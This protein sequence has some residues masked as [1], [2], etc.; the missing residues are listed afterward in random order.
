MSVLNT[1]QEEITGFKKTTN[2]VYPEMGRV[3]DVIGLVI[4]SRGPSARIGDVCHILDVETQDLIVKAEVVGFRDG[5]IQLMPFGELENL[6]VG[7]WVMNTHKPLTVSLSHALKGRILDALGNPL[8]QFGPVF[9][10]ETRPILATPPDA[11]SRDRITEILPLGVRAL[12][13]FLTMGQGQRMGIF[14]GSG[15]GKS[16]LQGMIARNTQADIN[17][18]ALIGE[19]GREVREFIEDALGEEGLSR[20]IVIV[21]TSEQAPVL[22]IKAA[23]TAA[24]IAEWFRDQ[25]LNVMF[26]LDSV[27]R[28]AMALREVG[29]AIGEPPTSRGYTPSVFTFLPKLLERCGTSDVGSITGL[30]TVLVEGD[31]FN[32]PIA[33]AVRG[34]L[35][36]HIVLSRELAY[37]NH[38]PAIDIL[39]SVSR[40]MHTI[41][42][43]EHRQAAGEIRDLI[44]TYQKSEDIISIGAYVQGANAKLDKAV[45]L[46]DAIDQFLKQDVLEDE[47]FDTAC[48]KL[49]QILS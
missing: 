28:I 41:S 42:E 34:I 18:I 10:E 39:S 44:A 14:A 26:M 43:P 15:V 49:K 31:D 7:S 47:P 30:Y 32:E 21:A 48:Q 37:Q 45:Q 11:M 33:D 36:G 25:G 46:K 6:A 3:E 27:T 1:L 2:T 16:T 4:Q 8:D 24:T 17:V 23:L 12:D 38:F 19:R 13:G 5:K 35:D 40:L 9:C 22:K 20:S 29:L